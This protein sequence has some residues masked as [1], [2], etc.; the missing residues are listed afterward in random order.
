MNTNVVFTAFSLTFNLPPEKQF[1]YTNVMKDSP[2]L[3]SL[4][5]LIVA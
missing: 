1:D 5:A 4:A 3:S 2:Y